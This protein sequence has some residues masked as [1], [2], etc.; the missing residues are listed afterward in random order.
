MR[1]IIPCEYLGTKERLGR[2]HDGGYV[3]DPTLSY[4]IFISC[5]I[6]DDI[7]FE[8][9]FLVKYP[10]LVC[11]AYDGTISQIPKTNHNIMWYQ[12]NISHTDSPTTTNLHATLDGCK[13]AFLKMDIEGAEIEWLR[14]VSSEQ[15]SHI[16][17]FVMEFH[18]VKPDQWDVFDKIF[19]THTLIH[20]HPNNC[21]QV[22]YPE[23]IPEVFEC[24]FVRTRDCTS[25]SSSEKQSIP[26]S[27]DQPNSTYSRE[28]SY[29]NDKF[30]Q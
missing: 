18:W 15:L 27:Y 4:D 2:N 24:T 12:T 9:A 25:L 30:V 19:E 16:K 20:M 26:S 6:N 29:V 8:E 22:N 11:Y 3:I 21:A 7:S 28:I 17:Q 23:N 1:D 14:S 10:D 5:G 13:D